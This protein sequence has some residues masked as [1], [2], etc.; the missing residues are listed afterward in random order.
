M[1]WTGRTDSES[2]TDLPTIWFSLVFKSSRDKGNEDR[3]DLLA[4]KDSECGK[5]DFVDKKDGISR[6]VEDCTGLAEGEYFGCTEA[7]A[8][9]EDTGVPNSDVVG[10]L[11]VVGVWISGVCHWPCIVKWNDPVDGG[12]KGIGCCE[13]WDIPPDVPLYPCQYIGIEEDGEPTS[14]VAGWDTDWYEGSTPV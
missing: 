5:D 9:Y 6:E 2:E 14:C 3:V 1:D 11:R 10:K 7:E 13:A 8:I 4:V 12:W